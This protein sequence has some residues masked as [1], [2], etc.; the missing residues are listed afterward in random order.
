MELYPLYS[1][2]PRLGNQSRHNLFGDEAIK[3]VEAGC[4]MCK[5]QFVGPKGILWYE[6]SDINT[7]GM[8]THEVAELRF[9]LLLRQP[10][11]LSSGPMGIVVSENIFLID[12]KAAICLVCWLEYLRQII[13]IGKGVT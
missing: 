5:K 4:L 2:H 1:Q 13:E 10:Q 6:T 3:L 9:A 8:A 7:V 11:F 12:R